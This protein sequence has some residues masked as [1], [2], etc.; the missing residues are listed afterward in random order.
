MTAED[1][2]SA[3]SSPV[4]IEILKIVGEKPRNVNEVLT[5]LRKRDFQIRYRESVYKALEK[6]VSVGL[7]SKYY[8]PTRK[9][10][11]Y[12]LQKARI[13]VDLKTGKLSCN[14]K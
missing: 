1:V 8:E 4:R 14:E 5:E 3:L 13:E 11:F 7:V 6:L 2:F 9:G 12:K 10:I